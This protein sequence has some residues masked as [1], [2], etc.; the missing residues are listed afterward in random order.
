LHVESYDNRNNKIYLV[1]GPYKI[2]KTPPVV[3]A[4]P[5]LGDLSDT[6]EVLVIAYDE[7]GSGIKEVWYSWTDANQ[8]PSSG[9]AITSNTTFY[10]APSHDGVWY[11]HMQAFDNAG[12]SFYKYTGPYTVESLAISDVTIEGYWNH[13]RGQVN[14]FG[15]RM[16]VEPHRFLS[17]ERVKINIYTE[18]YADKVEIR[19]SPELEEMQFRDRYGNLYDHKEDFNLDYVYFPIVINLD[20]SKK[21]NHVYWEYTLPLANSTKSWEDTV[22]RESYIMEVTVWKGTK[23]IKHVISDIDI[24]GNIYDL[25]YT[26]PIN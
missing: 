17:L 8:M 18:G 15:K 21:E 1:G 2:D 7:G 13:W 5:E 25:T 24:T 16:T 20:N 10:T 4:S 9:W 3:N 14:I 26:Q 11:L 22:L 12:N 6:D 19:F 23:S